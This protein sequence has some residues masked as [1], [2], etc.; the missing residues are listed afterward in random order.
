MKTSIISTNEVIFITCNSF[1]LPTA[2]DQSAEQTKTNGQHQVCKLISNSVSNRL[3]L[4]N[5]ST[6]KDYRRNGFT[7]STKTIKDK[8]KFNY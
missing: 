3:K 5:R 8:S 1:S 4:G 6:L 7:T 2:D